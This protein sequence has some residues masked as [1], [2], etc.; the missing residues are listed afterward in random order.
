MCNWCN[1]TLVA[2][3]LWQGAIFL[4]GVFSFLFIWGRFFAIP[5]F[6]RTNNAKYSLMM[7][8]V[9]KLPCA[10]QNSKA[11]TFFL[12]GLD[13][14]YPLLSTQLIADLTLERSDGS[15]FHPLSHIAWKNYLYCIGT[16]RNSALNRRWRV[17]CFWSTV[18]KWG[19]GF[20]QS[21]LM[22]NGEYI[23]FGYL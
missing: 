9:N 23:A 21:F 18:S 14:F 11:E 5:F 15:M 13:G 4:N 16:A 3:D 20:Q 10:T 17:C 6:E 8:K 22:Q 2:I 12:V 7:L 19:I 1:F